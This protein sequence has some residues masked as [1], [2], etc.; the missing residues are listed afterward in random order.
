LSKESVRRTWNDYY[1]LAEQYYKEHG[2]L[3]IPTKYVV[4]NI[5]LGIW[6]Y[7]QK[8]FYKKNTL[9]N[10]QIKKLENIGVKWNLRNTS[11]VRVVKTWDEN[12]GLAK[13]YYNEHKNL[14]IPRNYKINN[15]NLGNWLLNQTVYYKKNLL[16]VDQIKKLESIGVVWKRNESLWNEKY[17]LAEQ[18][19]KKNG[20]LNVPTKYKINNIDLGSW[21]RQQKNYFE[22]KLLTTEKIKKLESIGISWYEEELSWMEY[23]E[24]AIEYYKEHGDLLIP[25]S[26]IKNDEKLGYWVQK[27][28]QAFKKNKLSKEQKEKLESINMIW[29]C[30]NT[31]HRTVNPWGY[32]YELAKQYYKEHK[33]LLIS[34]KYRIN[35]IHLGEWIHTQRKYY[36]KNK[37]NQERIKLLNE[38]GMRW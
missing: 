30:R 35:D 17:E 12:F 36:K 14:L 23:Y 22:N 24:L 3:L 7:N 28:R 38:I 25:I 32:N 26:Y 20:H 27:Q 4:D 33:N 13:E 37:L 8:Q 2:D 18:F 19:Y 11:G 31:Y 21:I 34:N 6:L 10:E 29:S 5:K 15:D 1:E 16:I 9:N